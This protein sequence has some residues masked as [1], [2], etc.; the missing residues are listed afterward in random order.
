M[1]RTQLPEPPAILA[2]AGI[3]P[4][5]ACSIRIPTAV[6]WNLI[7]FFPTTVSLL[8]LS[9]YWHQPWSQLSMESFSLGSSNR[10]TFPSL[11][12]VTYD[13]GQRNKILIGQVWTI[14]LHSGPK[15]TC[16][17]QVSW[18]KRRVFPEESMSLPGEKELVTR[19]SRQQLY[20]E[21]RHELTI[22]ST[23]TILAGM[24]VSTKA[25]SLH[26]AGWH[27]V[28]E[29]GIRERS[30][31]YMWVAVQS[32]EFQPSIPKYSWPFPRRPSGS[33][34]PLKPSSWLRGLWG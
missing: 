2:C 30:R 22:P 9:A 3:T 7:G 33:P 32:W 13:R 31:N 25:S 27:R 28:S 23:E 4:S 18:R 11:Y 15:Q 26:R 34:T 1:N 12:W 19:S 21:G 8:P 17:T 10:T 6:T 16:Q 5:Q 29:E 24:N 20:W 14:C